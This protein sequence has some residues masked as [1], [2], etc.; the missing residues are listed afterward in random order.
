M[1]DSASESVRVEAGRNAM[2]TGARILRRRFSLDESRTVTSPLPSSISSSQSLTLAERVN[3][4]YLALAMLLAGMPSASTITN[5]SSIGDVDPT[6]AGSPQTGITEVRSFFRS[7]CPLRL[8]QI[9]GLT[10]RCAIKCL[11]RMAARLTD[12]SGVG[13][14]VRLLFSA[15][16]AGHLCPTQSRGRG[17]AAALRQSERSR[18]QRRFLQ[19]RPATPAPRQPRASR[20]VDR[21]DGGRECCQLDQQPHR[22]WLSLDAILLGEGADTDAVVVVTR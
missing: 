12:L 10:T 5:V 8:Y 4:A 18:P 17:R 14:F 19:S 16:S 15:A 11:R 3:T 21:A 20:G 6:L 7:V 1:M 9:R 2:R 13:S 22:H